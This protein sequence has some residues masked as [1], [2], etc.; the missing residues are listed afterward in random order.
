M[1]FSI[2]WMVFFIACSV[3]NTCQKKNGVKIV[4][5]FLLVVC[6]ILDIILLFCAAMGVGASG[7]DNIEKICYWQR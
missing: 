5:N 4:F 3:L 2:V 6:V 1:V 7:Y